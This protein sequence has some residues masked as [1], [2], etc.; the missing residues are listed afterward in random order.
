MAPITSKTDMRWSSGVTR[1]HR[2][3]ESL[4]IFHLVGMAGEVICC[5][6]DLRILTSLYINDFHAKLSLNR[7]LR[8]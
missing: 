6:R 5:L 4:S 8:G 7:Q 1:G 2:P 3:F